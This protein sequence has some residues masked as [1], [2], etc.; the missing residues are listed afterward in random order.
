[1]GSEKKQVSINT[2]TWLFINTKNVLKM[3]YRLCIYLAQARMSKN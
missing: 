3:I 1:M 2:E